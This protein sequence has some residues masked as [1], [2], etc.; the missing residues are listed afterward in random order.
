MAD[1]EVGACA[2][3]EP[4]DGDP[5]ERGSM[6]ASSDGHRDAMKLA[7][8]DSCADGRVCEQNAVGF[9]GGLCAGGCED[10]PE[11]TV[12]GGIALLREFNA[13]LASKTPFDR[14][15]AEHTRPGALA[16]CDA[17]TPCR[18]VFVCVRMAG[19]EGTEGTA[20]CLPPYFL[21]Q[22]R[23]DGHPL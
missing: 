16:A 4:T 18:D 22:A 19:T 23:I 1:D 10:L 3:P 15:L 20:A 8:R 17:R 11:G 21:F 2:S 5:C 7:A 6:R 13:C 14:C 9:P 12:C